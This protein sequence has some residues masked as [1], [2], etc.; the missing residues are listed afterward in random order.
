[1]IRFTRTAGVVSQFTQHRLLYNQIQ[2]PF[3][4]GNIRQLYKLNS[5]VTSDEEINH[6]IVI[7]NYR[8]RNDQSPNI[9]DI[10][11]QTGEVRQI[12]HDHDNI[13]VKN[14]KS[15]VKTSFNATFLPSGFPES[16]L[17][18][19]YKY[20]LLSNIGAISFTAMGFLSTQCLF[21]SIG[22]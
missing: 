17:P 16:V 7:K 22:A 21:V 9:I 10:D 2:R 12:S 18:G 20:T 15:K 4:R 5:I 6:K 1:M 19:Y 3:Q 13:N 8:D 14:M 11:N